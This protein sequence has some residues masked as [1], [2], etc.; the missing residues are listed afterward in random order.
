MAG[1][2]SNKKGQFYILIALLL[3]SYAFGLAR[4]DVPIRKSKDTFQLLH[5]GYVTEGSAII[6]NAAY[7][8]ANVTERFSAFTND[9]LAFARSAEPGF[10]LVYLLKYKGVL[11]VGNR[12]DDGLNVSVGS[13]SYLVGSGSS[14]EM[15]V[16]ASA[17]S[18]KISGISYDF[19]FSD[20]EIQLKA[21]FRT[22]DKLTT[23]VFVKK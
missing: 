18:F 20:E 8:G 1:L 22:S 23:S 11:A 4:H 7:D 21:V 17:A 10:R 16:P 12:L 9:Y 15:S 14:S 5:E 2:L 13:S 19:S 3:I 6:N